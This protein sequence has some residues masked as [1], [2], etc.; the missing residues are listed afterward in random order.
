MSNLNNNLTSLF[1]RLED[2]VSSKTVVGQPITIGETI[3]LPLI[4]VSFGLGAVGQEQDGSNTDKKS[5]EDKQGLASGAKMTPSA[6]IV[7]NQ[8]TSDVQLVNV[9]NQDSLNKLI[10][11]APGLISKIQN[12]FK[13]DKSDANDQDSELEEENE[14]MKS[15]LNNDKFENEI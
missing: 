8:K 13:K 14:I 4:D 5:S 11:M 3:I 12:A 9:K 1:D 7:I 15:I 2:F 10:D 6:V